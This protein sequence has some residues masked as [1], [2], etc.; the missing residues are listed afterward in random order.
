M[1]NESIV[2]IG[3][4]RTPM[5]GFQGVLSPLQAGEL[6]AVAIT[7]ALEQAG[8]APPRVFSIGSR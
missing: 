5:G 3:A 2:I 7:G 1:S 8:V 4:T 6:G